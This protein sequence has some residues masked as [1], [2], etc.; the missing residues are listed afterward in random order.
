M[1][2]W[3]ARCKPAV[4]SLSGDEMSTSGH[5][6]RL[7]KGA[8]IKGDKIVIEKRPRDASEAIAMKKSKKQKPVR[9]GR[10]EIENAK[11]GR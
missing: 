3:K 4:E 1:G 9:A 5:V 2:I 11:R 10:A 6:I 7:P 8:R